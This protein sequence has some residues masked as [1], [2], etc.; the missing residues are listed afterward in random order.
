MGLPDGTV[1]LTNCLQVG[2]FECSGV[3]G[4]GNGSGTFSG[5]FSNGYAS[6]VNVVNCHYLNQL[7]N[8]QGTQATKETLADGSVVS[9]L[10][11]SREDEIWTLNPYTEEPMLKMF[12]E[13]YN[14][15]GVKPI[16]NG[17]LRNGN[18]YTID[19]RQ[20]EKPLRNGFL[21]I[22]GIKAYVTQ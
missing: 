15:L 3:I 13:D 22:N 14:P 10:Q 2:T 11:A 12:V 1:T 9:A 5:V 4:G 16:L 20:I 18:Y 21:I 17:Q 8:A 7:G 6:R 19:G